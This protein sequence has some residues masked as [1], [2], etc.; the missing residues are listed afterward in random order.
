MAHD[1]AESNKIKK[2]ATRATLETRQPR[3]SIDFFPVRC[4]L[5]QT[6][7]LAVVSILSHIGLRLV[8]Y[9]ASNVW[10]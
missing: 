1:G 5:I 10:S 4:S 6:T 9:F 7:S 3:E 2:K 8:S